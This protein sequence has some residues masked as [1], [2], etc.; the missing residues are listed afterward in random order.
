MFSG[1][2]HFLLSFNLLNFV[3]YFHWMI[4]LI[5][6]WIDSMLYSVCSV[7]FFIELIF[8]R[9]S[10]YWK[11]IEFCLL[12]ANWMIL[13]LLWM[14]PMFF[15]FLFFFHWIYFQFIGFLLLNANW[16]ILFPLWLDPM[17]CST[18]IGSNVICSF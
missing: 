7:F 3:C 15:F 10:I 12:N 16:K 8:Q 5:L 11:F 18:L 17:S 13:F 2:S 4:S 1:F 6:F 9:V 14:A